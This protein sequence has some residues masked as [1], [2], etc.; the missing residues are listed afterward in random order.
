MSGENVVPL[1]SAPLPAT[2]STAAVAAAAAAAGAGGAGRGGT[3]GDVLADVIA[4]LGDVLR[5][6]PEKIDP[7]QTFQ[8]LGLDSLL[9]VEFV[10]VVN[11]RYGT[12]VPATEIADQPTPVA[13]AR[14]VA[15][16]AGVGGRGA[17]GAGQGGA[18]LAAV[19]PAGAVGSVGSAVGGARGAAAGVGDVGDVVE[20]LREQLAAILCCDAW[21]IDPGEAF[22]VLGLD[23]IL[24]AEFVSVVNRTF[25]LRERSV[26]LY[27]HP[28]LTA[29]AV[30]VAERAGVGSRGGAGGGRGS[31][32][33]G[34]ALGAGV[35]V[36]VGAGS[37]SALAARVAELD[38]VLDAVRDERLTVDEALVLLG[39]RGA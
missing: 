7:E 8:S 4:V 36:G 24:G 30:Y 39:R 18:A 26:V 15:R 10:A 17:V 28:N 5:V 29:M 38:V 20:V 27:D 1:W 37:V 34:S 35:G 9:T 19:G 22:G 25:G 31:G 21:D 23:S 14:Q 2:A 16:E 12:Q 11:A 32:G 6:K 33:V 13:F 3:R